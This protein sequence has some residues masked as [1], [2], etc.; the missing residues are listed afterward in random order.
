MLAPIASPALRG[1][2]RLRIFDQRT[3]ERL[4]ARHPD[5]PR[6][7]LI[8]LAL[9]ADTGWIRNTI[10][11]F[12]RKW[13]VENA[14]STAMRLFISEATAPGDVERSTLQFLY[15]AQTPDQVQGPVNVFDR[16]ALLQTRTQTY[17]APSSNRTIALVGLTVQTGA[18]VATRAIGGIA[19]YSKL[20][21]PKLQTTVQT[22]DVQYRVT[23]SFG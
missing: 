6:D 8:E 20:T 17:S 4:R 9:A 1:E 22:A 21:T 18:N 13:L 7:Y 15:P 3:F 2:F 23:W 12:G 11:D 10:T 19:A 16:A 5:W 14:F